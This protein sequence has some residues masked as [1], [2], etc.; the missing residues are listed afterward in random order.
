[1][2]KGRDHYLRIL[3][4]AEGVKQAEIKSAYRQLAKKFHPD[5]VAHLGDEVRLASEKRMKEILEAYEFL[6]DT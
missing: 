5:V 4:L 3:G 2:G 1:S 6:K